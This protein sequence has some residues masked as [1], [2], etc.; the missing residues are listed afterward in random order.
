MI[1]KIF[2]LES[3]KN[4]CIKVLEMHPIGYLLGAQIVKLNLSLPHEVDY[5][6]F[7]VLQERG[8]TG[9]KV[10]LDIG[11]NQGHSSRGF[12]KIL[13]GYEVI[14]FEALALHQKSLQKIQLRYKEKFTYYINSVGN[15]SKQFVEFFM[16][17]YY[18]FSLHS[19]AAMELE[20][21]NAIIYGMWPKLKN[22][23][24]LVIR[25]FTS[26]MIRIDDLNLNFNMMKLDIQGGEYEALIGME[27]SIALNQPII[28]IETQIGFNN[29]D[30]LLKNY[31]YSPYVYDA[32]HREFYSG[33]SNI[34]RNTFY[35]PLCHKSLVTNNE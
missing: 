3:I 32:A 34:G 26:N 30:K 33:I 17:Y 11:G 9:K 19:A 24:S 29:I 13:K 31:G 14:S 5:Y 20:S 16:P 15:D 7:R 25:K 35:I 21:V 27:K 18:G 4:Y 2:R 12:L 6:G 23:N 10:I 22:N 1:T 28:L 8:L